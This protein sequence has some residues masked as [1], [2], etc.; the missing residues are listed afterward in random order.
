[1][2]QENLKHLKDQLKEL[3][4]KENLNGKRQERIKNTLKDEMKNKENNQARTLDH[5]NESPGT[6]NKPKQKQIR[7]KGREG[8]EGLFM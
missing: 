6:T 1:M 7:Q 4:F 2:N 8:S 3:G 5:R